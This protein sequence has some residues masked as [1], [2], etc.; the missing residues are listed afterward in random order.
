MTDYIASNDLEIETGKDY[1]RK[2]SWPNVR[3][4]PGICLKGLMKTTIILSQ[5]GPT[6]L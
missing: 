5:V 6:S 2:R 3:Y 4:Y 1:G